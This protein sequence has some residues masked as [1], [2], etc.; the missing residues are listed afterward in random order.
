MGQESIQIKIS[1]RGRT[2][3]CQNQVSPLQ[4][5]L[6]FEPFEM[7]FSF[8][9]KIHTENHHCGNPS[10]DDGGRSKAR[11]LDNV[12]NLQ[13]NLDK[14]LQ[15]SRNDHARLACVA[16]VLF[17]VEANSGATAGRARE[18]QDNAGPVSEKDAQTLFVV[19]EG[20]GKM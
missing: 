17:K 2:R 19:K 14:L 13:S 10:G 12:A 7:I 9:K 18:A 8:T 3:R 15:S 1:V 5:G 20:E 11:E 16:L 6:D 4:R